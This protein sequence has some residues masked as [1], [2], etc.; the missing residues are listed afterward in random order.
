MNR[1]YVI[2]ASLV[3][4][5]TQ[6][7][8]AA[9]E[10]ERLPNAKTAPAPGSTAVTATTEERLERLEKEL[11]VARRERDVATIHADL[12]DRQTSW[13]ETWTSALI[14]CFSLLVTVLLVAFSFRFGRQ[15][16]EEAKA[17]ATA[18]LDKERQQVRSLLDEAKAAVSQIKADQEEIRAITD[19]LVAGQAPKDAKDRASLRE[20]AAEALKK[21]L[22]ER[23]A[24]E[25][26]SLIVVA[27]MDDDFE[28]ML[29]HAQAMEVLFVD[30]AKAETGDGGTAEDV[31]FALFNIAY[32]LG[33]LGRNDQ[34]IAAYNAFLDRFG[35]SELPALQERVA[36]ALFNKGVRLGQLGR[37]EDAIAAY[38]DV[39]ARFGGSALPALQEQV[40]MALV[41]KGVRLGQLGRSDDAIA[42]FDDV[43][44]RFG[45]STLPALQEQVAKALFNKGG[46]LGR[47]GR[48]AEAITA[49]DDVLARFGDSALPALQ[50]Q[51]A[52]ALVSKGVRLGQLGRSEDEIAAFDDVLARFG[53][54]ALPA[55]QEQVAN[56]LVNK[57]VP[58]GQLGRSED[59]I[60]AFDDVLARFGDSTLPALQERVASALFNKAC[61]FAKLVRVADCVTT[62]TQ[63]RDQIGKL[64][65]AEIA[66]DTDFD[67]VRDDPQFVAFLADNGCAPAP[68][69]PRPR[70]PRK[71]RKQ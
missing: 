65:C 11:D 10:G 53:G 64:D 17:A 20:I 38:D 47:L 16:V 26:R 41:N 22:R 36:N 58:L 44:A 62:L 56:A 45:D 59:A 6:P 3:M 66:N 35:S 50:E 28:T 2:L 43:L 40:A 70:R 52:K 23:S 49:Y 39:L 68:S 4:S 48:A 69:P 46:A 37:F 29:R 8:F 61:A 12:I 67:S 57:G 18:D 32:A 14:G 63:W 9:I 60:A 15:A 71:P 24:A 55:L 30:D 1:A 33:K 7:A 42:A 25:Y 27:F 51:V 13:Y 21:P 34:S 31:A 54:S 5:G 19:A